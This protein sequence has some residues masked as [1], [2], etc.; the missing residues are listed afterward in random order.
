[1]PARRDLKWT[2]MR[3]L[4]HIEQDRLDMHLFSFCRLARKVTA[5]RMGLFNS[6]SHQNIKVS[7]IFREKIA[8]TPAHTHTKKGNTNATH[9]KAQR[10]YFPF[11]R[12]S[13]CRCWIIAMVLNRVTPETD[14]R[15][16]VQLNSNGRLH[17]L[18]GWSSEVLVCDA[19]N[20]FG[21]NSVDCRKTRTNLPQAR[22]VR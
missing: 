2:T 13:L 21:W 8:T 22:G 10:V 20:S 3:V 14:H 11:C 4:H 15:G 9:N 6:A 12:S 17:Q 5:I 18:F 7:V 1:M 16:V 19:C